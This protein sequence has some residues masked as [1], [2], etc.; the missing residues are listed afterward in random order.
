MNTPVFNIIPKHLPPDDYENCRLVIEMN[1]DYFCYTVL[2]GKSVIGLKY[3]QLS[4][5][6][7]QEMVNLLEETV[8]ED[9]VLKEK[10][11]SCSVLFNWPENCLVPR[12]H[13]DKELNKGMLALMYGYLNKGL[14]LSEEINGSDMYIIY[15]I[16]PVLDNFFQRYFPACTYCHYY[17]LWLDYKFKNEQTVADHVSIVFNPKEI[18]VAVFLS[19]KIQV[20]QNLTYQTPEDIAWQILNIYQRFYLK[21]EETPLLV[22]GMIDENSAMYEELLKYFQ[23]V[24][25]ER[26]PKQI[27]VPEELLSFPEHF[28][29]PLLKLAS[30]VS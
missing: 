11:M 20:I 30:C 13:F 4:Y 1:P 16:P 5:N 23:F 27:V 7:N 22:G 14:M 26:M 28:F 10:M 6:N 2:H 24:E 15:R 9:G 12:T 17:N 19:N 18:I 8:N 3:Y 25:L 21:Q 29:S